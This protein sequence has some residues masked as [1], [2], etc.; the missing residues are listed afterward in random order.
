MNSTEIPSPDS[1]GKDA[2]RSALRPQR[3]ASKRLLREPLLHFLFAAGLLFAIYAWMNPDTAGVDTHTIV[4]TDD[5]LLQMSIVMRSQGY[6][7]PSPAQYQSM[8]D[9]KVREEVLY[10]EA[11]AMG[12]EQNDTIVK[13]RMA[14]KMD[15]L[16]E[17]ISD[18]RDPTSAELHEWFASHPQDFAYPPRVTF[19]H[20]YFSFDDHQAQTK[21][22]AASALPGISQL[23]YDAPQIDTLGDR[24]MYQDHYADRNPGQIAAIFGGG[25]SRD[26]FTLKPGAWAGPIESGF[27]WHLVYIDEL[28]PGETPH[29]DAV[30]ADVKAAWMANQRS[31]FKQAAYDMMRAKYEVELPPSLGK[32]LVAPDPN[33]QPA[34]G[35]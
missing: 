19:R 23:S 6:P 4:L 8:I 3:F 28:T 5:D 24:F 27:G 25:F 16:A 18:L 7:E 13:R 9:S 35:F 2:I 1:E 20:V 17:D 14:Q 32:P 12:L 22:V 29:F 30:E 10:L 11:V 21:A 34:T 33:T 26:L 31:E 15:F